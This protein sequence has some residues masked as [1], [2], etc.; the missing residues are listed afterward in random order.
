MADLEKATKPMT[1][2][3]R[4]K[5]YEAIYNHRIPSYLPYFLRLD[6]KNFSKYTRGLKKTF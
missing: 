3:S 2:Y 6:G 5:S 1:I 4:M